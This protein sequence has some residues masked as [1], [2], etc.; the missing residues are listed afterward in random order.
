MKGAMSEQAVAA[1]KELNNNCDAFRGGWKGQ[2]SLFQPSSQ[3][4][5]VEMKALRTFNRNKKSVILDAATLPESMT[6]V[7]RACSVLGKSEPF[8]TIFCMTLE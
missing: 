5:S 3:E 2:P 7:R 4:D 8:L 1:S 6:L